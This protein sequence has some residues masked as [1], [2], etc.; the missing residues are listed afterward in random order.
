MDGQAIEF[1]VQ[2]QLG[3]YTRWNGKRNSTAGSHC[4]W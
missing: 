3:A 2:E 1:P 4:I